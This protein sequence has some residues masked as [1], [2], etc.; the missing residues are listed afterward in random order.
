MVGNV[1]IFMSFCECPTTTDLHATNMHFKVQCIYH[2]FISEWTVFRIINHFKKLPTECL[3]ERMKNSGFYCWFQK[4]WNCPSIKKLILFFC[5][6]LHA[7]LGDKYALFANGFNIHLV[8][9]NSLLNKFQNGR[10]A[11]SLLS[12]SWLFF[13]YST[14]RSNCLLMC[15]N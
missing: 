15:L 14:E 6:S 12:A 10:C 9:S 8:N 5:T 4:P 13:A 11:S 2:F 3:F 7:G 1:N